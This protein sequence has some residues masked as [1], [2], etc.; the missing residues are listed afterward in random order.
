M[1]VHVH[2]CISARN[3]GSWKPRSY[4]SGGSAD[5]VQMRRLSVHVTLHCTP[6]AVDCGGGTIRRLLGGHCQRTTGKKLRP[7]YAAMGERV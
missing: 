1:L 7:A 2:A 5:S 6:C 4:R 3:G